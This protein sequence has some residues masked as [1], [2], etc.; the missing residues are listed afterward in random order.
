MWWRGNPLYT[1]KLNTEIIHHINKNGLQIKRIK[2]I[3]CDIIFEN[4]TIIFIFYLSHNNYYIKCT[5]N[6]DVEHTAIKLFFS[7][8]IM[9]QFCNTLLCAQYLSILLAQRLIYLH[10]FSQ[11]LYDDDDCWQTTI[12]YNN[13]PTSQ[14]RN[15]K[16][17]IIIINTQCCVCLYNAR[18]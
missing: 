10:L 12:H 16:Y 18:Y 8:F 5:H 17:I 3:L 7:F 15:I 14:V 4:F 11:T 6:N 13:K 1:S 9:L 2:S